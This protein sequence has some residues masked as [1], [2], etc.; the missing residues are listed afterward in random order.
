MG[1]G[2][3]GGGGGYIHILISLYI[4][5]YSY[6]PLTVSLFFFFCFLSRLEGPSGEF[7][8]PRVEAA[9]LSIDDVDL[10]GRMT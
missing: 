3:G 4:C 9:E 8:P 2:E 5:M 1:G 7:P 10:L 6:G